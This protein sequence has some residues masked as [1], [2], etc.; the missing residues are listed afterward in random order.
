VTSSRSKVTPIGR[1]RKAP[2]AQAHEIKA[3]SI[4]KRPVP[5][6]P[7]ILDRMVYKFQ[8]G[9]LQTSIARE[10]ECSVAF[11]EAV[12]RREYRRMAAENREL[13]KAA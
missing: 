9:V 13:R 10:F 6:M 3:Q 8:S 2:T 1:D 12:I 7:L 11:V 4:P 5:A